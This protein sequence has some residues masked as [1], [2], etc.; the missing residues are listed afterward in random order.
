MSEVLTPGARMFFGVPCTSDLDDV[1]AHVA[2]LGLP[3]D[4]G[5]PQPGNRTGQ[6]LGPAAARQA[7]S[8]QFAYGESPEDGAVGWYDIEGDRD[9]LRGVTMVDLGTM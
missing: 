1:T 4:G 9:R 8:E 5:T 2:F 7:S 3:F 6:R